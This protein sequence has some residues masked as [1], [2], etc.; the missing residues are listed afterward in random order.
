M[1]LVII[2]RQGVGIPLDLQNIGAIRADIPSGQKRRELRKSFWNRDLPSSG[3]YAF[4]LVRLLLI[5]RLQVPQPPARDIPFGGVMNMIARGL[6]SWSCTGGG[7]FRLW[8]IADSRDRSANQGEGKQVM[9]SPWFIRIAVGRP[10]MAILA[11]SILHA[12]VHAGEAKSPEAKPDED[13]IRAAVESYVAAY[14]RGDGKAVADHWADRAEWVSPS[15]QRFQGRQA[16]QQAM[17]AMFAENKE[18]KI[19]VIDPVVR[20]LTPEVALEEGTVRV[21]QPGEVPD[22]AKYIAIHSKKNGQWK[23]ESVRETSLPDAAPSHLQVKQLEWLVG[24][25]VDESP[26]TVVEHRCWWSEDGHFLLGRFVVQ[27]EG[28]PAMKGDLRIGWDPLARQIKSWI[29]DSEGGFAEG[30]WTKVGDRWVVKST[31]VRPDG[32]TASATNTYT[33]LGRDQYQFTSVDR[34]L[35]GQLE[36]DQTVKIV[37]KP[38][39]PTNQ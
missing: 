26:N 17:E 14:N 15:G 31:G 30:M 27:W 33:P 36:P 9:S 5:R 37:R 20:L 16:I 35:G 18:V 19:E 21:I 7:V 1:G 22:D 24:E 34:I 2:D 10:L 39:R 8:V 28:G 25:W 3:F 38:P 23:L 29:F 32:S 6:R 4:L 11:V 12:L 13:A